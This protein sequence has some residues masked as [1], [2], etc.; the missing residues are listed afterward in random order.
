[1]VI[2]TIIFALVYLIFEPSSETLNFLKNI[3]NKI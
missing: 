2:F 3:F 1:M